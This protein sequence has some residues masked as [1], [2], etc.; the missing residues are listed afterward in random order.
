MAWKG[1]GRLLRWFQARP[2]AAV[3]KLFVAALGTFLLGRALGMRF[4]GALLAGVVFA[5]CLYF[6]VWL[7]WP[8]TSVWALMPW[9]LWL[10]DR[11]VRRPDLASGAALAGVV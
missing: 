5:F 6:V 1:F 3:L 10:T 4:A 8:L 2:L 7:P 9:L 11:L